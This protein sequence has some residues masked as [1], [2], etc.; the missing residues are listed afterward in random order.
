MKEKLLHREAEPRQ[1]QVRVYE[2]GSTHVVG[3]GFHVRNL[4]PSNDI[5]RAVSPF[6]MLDYAGPTF[7]SATDHPRGVGEHPHRGFET[8][9]ILYQGAV[10]HRDS[11]G[12]SGVIGPGDVQWM[13]AASGVVHEERH[14]R[15]WAK[16][17]GTLQAVQ[18]WVNLPAVD[19][20]TEPRYQTLVSEAIPLVPLEGGAGSVRVIAG[21]FGGAK[22]PATTVT[23]MQLLDLRLPAQQGTV[24]TFAA[25]WNVALFVLSGQVTV[26]GSKPVAEA[27]LAVLTSSGA[28][29]LL[30][31]QE[32]AMLLVMAGEPLNEP[33]VRYGPFVMNS[34]SELVQ[35][36]NDYRAGKMGHLD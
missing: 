17:G 2:P 16:Q 8:V 11:A 1:H 9:T 27:Q 7:Y 24:L 36:V 12:N 6:L 23:P 21:E 15:D 35:A 14:E 13:T 26:N 3:D 32:D 20:M 29:I 19:K 10:A 28:P 25:G 5:D 31:A 4:F 18:L 30:E 22:G 34:Q 33:I